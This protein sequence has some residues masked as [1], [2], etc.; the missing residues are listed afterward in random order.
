MT[1]DSPILSGQVEW[2]GDNPG[3]YL[4]ESETAPWLTLSV[5]FRVVMSPHG[6]GHAVVVLEEPD[7]AKSWPDCANLCITDNEPMM[8][9]LYAD[10]LSN[11]MTFRNRKGMEAMTWLPL[12]SVVP[13]GD[14]GGE[15][16]ETIAAKDA[17]V[18]MIWR[19]ASRRFAANVPAAKGPTGKHA[20]LSCF[21]GMRDADILVNGRR[22]KGNVTERDFLDS[23]FSTAFLAF[24]ETWIRVAP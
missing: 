24:S 5:F 3:I 21:V 19:N 7:L 22:L 14:P 17:K 2:T 12:T 9:Y 10:F 6:R 8:R 18:E 11:F 13:S 23:R 4:R 20:M 1:D 15:Y 16:R